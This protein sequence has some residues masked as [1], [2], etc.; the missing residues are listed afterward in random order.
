MTVKL[1][2]DGKSTKHLST[3]TDAIVRAKKILFLSGAGISCSAGIPDFRSMN[4]LYNTP[5]SDRIKG[6]D[7]F[8]VS[9]FNNAATTAAFYQ[10]MALLRTS[11]CDARPTPTHRFLRTLKDRGSLLRAYTQNIDGLEARVGLNLATLPLAK[12]DTVQLHGD[13]HKLKCFLCSETFEYNPS[14]QTMLSTGEAPDCPSC[15]DKCAMRIAA[16]RRPV[17]IGTLRPD[18]VLYGEQ[19]PAGDSIAEACAMDLKKRPDCLIIAG[20]TLKVP[21]FK[22]LVKDFAKSVHERNGLVIFVNLTELTSTE[23]SSTIDFHV[24]CGSDEFVD[25]LKS[26][27]PTFF[28]KQTT[29]DSALRSK[30]VV[31][32]IPK[33]AA[34]KQPMTLKTE[35][36]SQ[37]SPT[38]KRCPARR[39]LS[40]QTLQ[41]NIKLEEIEIKKPGFE[42]TVQEISPD[43]NKENL[44]PL[45]RCLSAVVADANGRRTRS[46]TPEL[47]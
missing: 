30:K 38:K 26:A 11:T 35:R 16:G 47:C 20:T 15:A 22:K 19:H 4:G 36:Q 45:K 14:F 13:I 6:K 1:Q 12:S 21:G 37:E 34:K 17:A 25:H 18:I 44:N 39:T 28:T 3:V 9:L 29:L 42:S 10:F 32:P 27:R 46:W 24:H 31:N 33:I 23:F 5:T 7:L 41:S 8:D 40:E 43:E 2:L